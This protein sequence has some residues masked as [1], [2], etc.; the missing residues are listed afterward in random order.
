MLAPQLQYRPKG[1]KTQK[2]QPLLLMVFMLFFFPVN[3]FAIN[4]STV[5]SENSN[6]SVDMQH[7][8]D[9]TQPPTNGND[10][11][12]NH[13][14]AEQLPAPLPIKPPAIQSPPPQF[15]ERLGELVPKGIMFHDENGELVDAHQFMD[16]PTVIVPVFFSCP[17]AC[18]TLQSSVAMVLPQ[19]DLIPGKD[20]RVITIS[21]DETDTPE[22]AKRKKNNYMAAMNFQFPE[23]EWVYLTGELES[24]QNFMQSIGFPYTRLGIGNFA[25]PLGV[26]VLAPNG[27]V[28]RY[29]YGQNFMPVDFTMALTEAAEGK[30]GLSI[31][32]LVTYCF[33]YD[34]SSRQ[35]VFN[36]MRV[37]G[38]VILFGAGV[39]LVILLFGGKKKNK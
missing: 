1:F 28:A 6:S 3:A 5:A 27:K 23:Q 17:G 13:T 22:L 24:I 37:A 10:A 30:T 33:T 34:P 39:L 18:N 2:Y 15:I 4:H 12:K 36:F 31:K 19:I 20:F 16:I 7:Q 26:V 35:Y 32:R 11:H 8:V 38:I 9:S 29:L 21:F 14:Q 25:H